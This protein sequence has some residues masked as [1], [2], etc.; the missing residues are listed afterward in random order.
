MPTAGGQR[1]NLHSSQQVH[2]SP[3]RNV[4]VQ[5]RRF[6]LHGLDRQPACDQETKDGGHQD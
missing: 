3:G 5:D 4:A 6:D 1:A 2:L